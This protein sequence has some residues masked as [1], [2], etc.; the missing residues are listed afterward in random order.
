MQLKKRLILIPE[1]FLTTNLL[2]KP[3]SGTIVGENDPNSTYIVTDADIS[4]W[5]CISN[6]DYLITAIGP[7]RLST[8]QN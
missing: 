2:I 6:T 7:R 3:N 4:H 1:K 8:K 5:N